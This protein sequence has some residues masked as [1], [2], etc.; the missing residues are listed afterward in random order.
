MNLC[1]DI[2]N[3]NIK[4]GHFQDDALVRVDRLKNERAVYKLV[5]ATRPEHVL[6]SSVNKK[7]KKVHQFL[8]RYTKVYVMDHQT[9]LPIQIDY[10]TPQTL[11]LDRLAAAVG[12]AHKFPNRTC[13]VID[14]GTCIT[15][16]LIDQSGIYH[17]GGIS[18]G[19]EMRLKSM[20]K[21]TSGL[22]L[23]GMDEKAPL[24][25][26]STKSCLQSGAVQGALAEV[27]GIIYRY[28]QF[29]ENL[30]IILC[31]GGAKFFESKI[32]GHIFANPDLVLIGQNQIL[33][34]ILNDK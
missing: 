6:V 29:Y 16:D 26:T 2:G 11:G 18:P 32:N 22:P 1:I 4:V 17:G 15:Y 30:T 20:H 24:V 8:T 31:G 21:Y 34:N 27:E 9:A 28:G 33:N 13:L 14:I 23:V 5:K 10:N 19:I 3:T 7:R 12:A 25:G